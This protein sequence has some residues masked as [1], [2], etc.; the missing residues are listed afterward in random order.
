MFIGQQL[1]SPRF[2]SRG[3]KYSIRRTLR[4]YGAMVVLPRQEL[5]TFGRH[6][7]SMLTTVIRNLEKNSCASQHWSADEAV[8]LPHSHN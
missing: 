3:A 4:T 2:H 7:A 8:F 1:R 6:A 5:E